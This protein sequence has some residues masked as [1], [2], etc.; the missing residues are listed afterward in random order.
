MIGASKLRVV[1]AIGI[2]LVV[3][4]SLI[5]A[6]VQLR[7]GSSKGYEHGAAYLL[8]AVV[9]CGGYHAKRSPLYTAAL[10]TWLA[11]G[12]ELA[13]FWSPG[14]TPSLADW[15]SGSFGALL[16]IAIYVAQRTVWERYLA[17]RLASRMKTQ[18]AVRG[19]SD[20]K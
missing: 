10:L 5:P 19:R 7:T 3:L 8:L 9:C 13:Q 15:F 16:G 14:R 11:G 4:L 17:V 18:S 6:E 12:L 20:Q 2:V 1:G